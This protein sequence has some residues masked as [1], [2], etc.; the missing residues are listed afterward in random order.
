MKEYILEIYEKKFDKDTEKQASVQM[1]SLTN[2]QHDPARIQY[3]ILERTSK[4]DTEHVARKA[5]TS[6]VIYSSSTL[7]HVFGLTNGDIIFRQRV[8]GKETSVT[9]SKW[10]IVKLAENE[11][12]STIMFSSIDSLN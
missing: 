7:S 2:P 5:M 10:S 12:D 9:A 4:R 1:K 6:D 8:D 3:S 11:R